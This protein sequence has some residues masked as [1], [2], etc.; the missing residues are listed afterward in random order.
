MIPFVQLSGIVKRFPPDILANDRISFDVAS[1]EIHALLGENGAGK[2]TLMQ[3]LYGLYRKDA[4]EIRIEG[5]LYEF[6][7]PRDAIHHGIGMIHQEF[8]LVRSFTVAE[9]VAMGAVGAGSKLDLDSVARRI[10]NLAE[11]FGL[12]IDP[13]ARIEHLSLGVQQR[14]EILKLLYREA[15]LL[16]LDEPTSVLTPQEVGRLFDVLRALRAAG[17]SI[18][19]VT[20]KLREVIDIADRVTVLRDGRAIATLPTTQADEPSLARLMVGRDVLLR[21]NKAP[22]PPG[23]TLLQVDILTVADHGGQPRVKNLSLAVHAGEILGIAGVDGNGQSELV[24]CLFGLRPAAAGRVLLE[25]RDITDWA[26]AA[27]R[28]EHIAYLPADRRHVG[29]VGELSLAD[30]GV[31]GWQRRFA[32]WGGIWRDRGRSTAHARAL[33]ER[34][35]VRAPGPDFPVGK[36]SGGNLQKVVLGREVMREPSVLLVE[37]PTRGLDVG[38][39]EMV[40]AELLEQRAQ[41][42]GILLVSAELE[43]ILNLADRIAVIFGGEIMGVLPAAD[44]TVEVLG[45]MMAGRHLAD[46]DQA[47]GLEGVD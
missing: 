43:E 22:R 21:A 14:V 30:N 16:I 12:D 4:G 39:I 44:A 40:W 15:R 1:G 29:S 34:F 24:E 11:E 13:S 26:P 3:I 10:S 35:G 38:A 36:L 25:G 20:H 47:P 9:N 17:K 41:G 8:M 31:L 6:E 5:K 28:N 23:R 46:L 18:V 2:S 33:I 32:R 19:M 45:L 42:R 7:T 37:Q 27:R